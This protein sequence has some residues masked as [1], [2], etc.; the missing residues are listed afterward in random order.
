MRFQ[1]HVMNLRPLCLIFNHW[2]ISDGKKA[3]PM[4]SRNNVIEWEQL[5]N[6]IHIDS[7]TLNDVMI[8]KEIIPI[9]L[10][11]G[12]LGTRLKNEEEIMWDPDN[13]KDFCSRFGLIKPDGS[14]E[15]HKVFI[16]DKAYD[17]TYLSVAKD[18]EIHLSKTLGW[19][20]LVQGFYGDLRMYQLQ[21]EKSPVLSLCFENPFYAFGYNWTASPNDIGRILAD[22]IKGTVAH[23]GVSSRCTRVILVTHSMGGLVARSASHI[24]DAESS[25]LGIIHTVQPAS[26]AP[27]AYS[28]MKE[29]YKV[30]AEGDPDV[31]ERIEAWLLGRNGREM[32]ATLGNMPGA[33]SLLPNHLY[34]G[35]DKDPAWLQMPI[36]GDGLPRSDPYAEI[37][38]NRTHAWRLIDEHLLNPGSGNSELDWQNYLISLDEVERFHRKLGAYQHSNSFHIVGDRI[39]TVTFCYYDAWMKSR[40][41]KLFTPTEKFNID[42]FEDTR[43]QGLILVHKTGGFWAKSKRDNENDIRVRLSTGAPR[44]GD[45]TVPVCS[46]K[47]LSDEESGV[48]TFPFLDHGNAMKYPEV[49]RV[50]GERI[51]EL[52]FE[53]IYKQAAVKEVKGE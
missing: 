52:L 36:S 47:S 48:T 6:E 20:N 9:I 40:K 39:N 33:L 50:I 2:A 10:V 37:Y 41:V 11:P 53:V 23:H 25:I 26:G 32:T 5:F 13:L 34:Q 28:R 29:G 17:N 15:R 3:M 45:G 4:N 46:A 30:K 16:G 42:K 31:L 19:S 38:R 27:A 1:K 12:F 18:E 14:A 22:T 21:R 49:L 7:E 35:S 8:R 43:L 44:D 51:D 24:Y